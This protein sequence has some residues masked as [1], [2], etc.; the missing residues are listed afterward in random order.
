[1]D[2]PLILGPVNNKVSIESVN[3]IVF[4][5]Y[6]IFLFNNKLGWYA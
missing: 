5:T 2:L 3:E 1:M 4:G 6:S